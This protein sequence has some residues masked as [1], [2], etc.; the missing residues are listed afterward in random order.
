MRRTALSMPARTAL[1]DGVLADGTV[2][3]YGCGHGGDVARLNAA[4]ISTTGWDPIL[5]PDPEPAPADAVLCTYVIN[6]IEDP[7]ERATTLQ[8]VWRLTDRVLV[9]SARTPHDTRRLTGTDL[10]DGLLTSRDTFQRPFPPAELLRFVADTLQTHALPAAPGVVYAFKDDH[11]RMAYLT[12]RY[13]N[14]PTSDHTAA[15]PE[16]LANLVQWLHDYGRL[17][18]PEEDPEVTRRVRRVFGS[19]NRAQAAATTAADPVAIASARHR[20]QVNLLVLLAIEAFHGSR[21]LTDLPPSFQADCRS[22]YP[23]FRQACNRSD[24]LLWALSQP[25]QMARA[26]RAS[27]VGKLTPTALYV[28]V[29]AEHQLP[30]LLRVYAVCGELLVGRPPTSNLLKLHHDKSA[31]SFLHYPDFDTDA[32]PKLADSLHVDL[33]SQRAQWQDWSTDGNRPLLHRKE[34]FLHPSDPR[35]RLYH[36]LTKRE[37]AAGLY[38]RP[39]TIG[40]ELGWQRILQEAGYQ[41]RGHRLAKITTC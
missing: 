25:A 19:I 2:L 17:P 18:I 21:R 11:A 29:R 15:S 3:D 1:E 8:Q 32:H 26:M 13:A 41:V 9:V 16:L 28:H 7:N 36:R 23:S 37:V 10:A 30:A 5:N 40:R 35:W 33:R 24:W 14:T 4:G 22:F 38:Q 6:T 20:R 27:K 39:S 31:V 12:Q 34:E